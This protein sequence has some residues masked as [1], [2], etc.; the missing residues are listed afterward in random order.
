MTG[1]AERPSR[2]ATCYRRSLGQRIAR[3][4]TLRIDNGAVPGFWGA[5]WM[6]ALRVILFPA[7]SAS[8]FLGGGTFGVKDRHVSVDALATGH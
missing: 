2:N 3:T 6:M 1:F 5:G 4:R 7:I 8:C